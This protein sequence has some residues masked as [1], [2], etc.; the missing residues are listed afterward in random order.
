MALHHGLTLTVGIL[1]TIIS[2]MVYLAPVPTFHKVYKEKSIK[3]FESFPYVFELFIS[4]LWIH[5]AILKR[6]ALLIITNSAGCV[7][8]TL[9][10]VIFL[11][12]APKKSKIQTVLLILLIA[13]GYGLMVISTLFLANGQKRIQIVE[14]I[15]LVF[16]LIVFAA[17]LCIMRKVIRTKNVEFMPFPLSFFQTLGAVTWFFYWLLLKD[18][19]FAFPNLLGFILGIVQMGLYI[20]YR[21]SKEISPEKPMVNPGLNQGVLQPN[22]SVASVIDI[23]D[24]NNL[25]GKD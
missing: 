12:Y 21:N 18:Y 25:K 22:D 9:Y 19:K 2:F 20:A 17:P 1:G 5:Y 8:E 14:W 6:A 23:A 24:D 10:I 15:C 16:K 7:M 3:G 11:F 13:L 4:M